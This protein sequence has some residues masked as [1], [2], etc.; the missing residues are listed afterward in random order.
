MAVRS[1]W[2]VNS[3][4]RLYILAYGDIKPIYADSMCVNAIVY[5]N[6]YQEQT[7]LHS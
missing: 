4:Q 2:H 3:K 1:G 7:D 5:C 6:I